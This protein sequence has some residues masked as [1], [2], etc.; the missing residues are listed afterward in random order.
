MGDRQRRPELDGLRGLAALIVLVSHIT[1][2]SGLAGGLLGHGA[3]Q[4]G[5]MLFF[6]LSGFLMGDL[7]LQ[8]PFSISRARV[9]LVRRFARIAPLYYIA[10]AAAVLL[11]SLDIK[12]YGELG[13]TWA[14]FLFIAADNSVF[15]TVPTEV[16]FYILFALLWAAT[17]CC[18]PWLLLAPAIVAACALQISYVPFFLTGA[19][20]SCV[21]MTAH[22]TWS[23][24]FVASLVAT[25]L[26][27]PQVRLA[28]FGATGALWS[29]PAALAATAALIFTAV[30]SPFARALLGN[31]PMVAI[32]IISYSTYLLHPPAIA[33]M[34]AL[35]DAQAH[36]VFFL[37]AA[38]T[39]TLLLA[40]L[41]YKS[42]EAPAR[43]LISSYVAA[44]R[45]D[46]RR[47]HGADQHA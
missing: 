7:Y 5:V 28:L 42:L 46:P 1:N 24:P 21:P 25:L 16:Q 29:D 33:L 30:R 45:N 22:R 10:F 20:I 6:V 26:L 36:P 3:G 2:V 23:V 35:M 15:W 12:P 17:W 11:A 18:R 4:I 13:P 37:L 38:T 31:T 43:T 32:G 39:V 34:Q 40:S 9:Y 44:S 41:S 27:F 19:L 14:A 8:R 47:E